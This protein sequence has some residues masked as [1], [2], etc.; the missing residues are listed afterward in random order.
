MRAGGDAGCDAG[1]T[2]SALSV[3]SGRGESSEAGPYEEEPHRGAGSGTSEGCYTATAAIA[4]TSISIASSA[5]RGTGIS[6]QVGVISG[7]QTKRT[8]ATSTASLLSL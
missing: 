3:A 1:V 2:A 7:P 5:R 4:S 8:S 6:V